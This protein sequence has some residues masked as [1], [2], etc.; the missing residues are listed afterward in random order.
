MMMKEEAGRWEQHQDNV[1]CV[2][3]Q[4]NAPGRDFVFTNSPFDTK[5]SEDGA[6]V[7]HITI[8]T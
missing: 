8:R 2:P 5:K 7:M 3:R 4:R 1:Y 6:K